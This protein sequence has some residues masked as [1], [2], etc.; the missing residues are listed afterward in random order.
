MLAGTAVAQRAS[1]VLEDWL[2][3]RLHPAGRS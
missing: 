1:R 3:S 2:E